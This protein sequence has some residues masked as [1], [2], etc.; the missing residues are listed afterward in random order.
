MKKLFLAGLLGL[1][2]SSGAIA[3]EYLIEEM[4]SLK[5]TLDKNDPDRSILSIRLADLYFD[6]SIQEGEND[7]LVEYREKA[8]KLYLDV[9]NGRDGIKKADAKNATLIRYNIARVLGKLSRFDEARNYYLSVFESEHANER[10]K[11][12]AAFSLAE[13]YEEKVN[14]NK[15]DQYYLAG[16]ELCNSVESCNYAHYKRAWLHYKEVKLDTAISELKQSLFERDGSVREKVINDLLL[17]FSS[18]LTNGEKELAYIKELRSKTGRKDLVRKLVEAFYAAGNRIAGSTVLVELNKEK[19]DPFYEMRLLE[20]FYGFR[21][22]DLV[23]EYL[24]KL[25]KR[26]QKELPA[27]KEEAK[28]FKAMLKRVIVQFDS[29]AESNP[30]YVDIL[31]R[32]IDRYLAFYPNDDMRKKMQQGWLK[33]ESSEEN[34]IA[35]LKKWIDEDI[36][37]GFDDE[38]IRKLRQTRLSMA[39]KLKKSDIVKVESLAIYKLLTKQKT[40]EAREFRYVYAHENYKSKDFNIAL[41]IFMELADVSVVN[42]DEYAIKSQHLALDILNQQKKYNEIVIQADAWLNFDKVLNDKN[43]ASDLKEIKNIRKQADFEAV[44]QL[45]ENRIALERFYKFCFDKVYEEKSCQNAKVL[46]IKLADQEKLISLLE[47]AKDEKALV[48][49]YE[50][51]GRF[52]DTAKLQEKFELTRNADIPVYLKI[53]LLYEVDENFSDRDRILKKL[54]NKIRRDKKIESKYETLVFN[55]LDQAGLID[56]SSLILPWNAERKISLANRLVTIKPTKSNQSI[57]TKGLSYT[58][59]TWAKHVLGEAQKLY[60]RQAKTKFYG[61]YS[62]TLFKRR[63]SRIE[64]FSRYAKGY[65]EGANSE[66]RIY[67]LDLLAKAY[68]GLGAEILNTPIPEGLTEE[69]LMQVQANLTQMASPY[70]LVAEDYRRLQTEEI[71]KLE[72]D[73]KTLISGNLSQENLNYASLIEFEEFK[74]QRTADVDFNK[75]RSYKTQ[76]NQKPNDLEILTKMKDE[77]VNHNNMRMAAYFT[78]RI[79]ALKET[80]E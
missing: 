76:L 11:R 8:L 18:D 65:L 2:L 56:N 15:A 9:L 12:E 55:T 37:Y 19:P 73:E 75:I 36:S 69:I 79:Q 39:Q 52:S 63:I 30:L 29:E 38:H 17:F 72:E 47:K 80:H 27:T 66:T 35:R 48:V 40:N 16:I 78:G 25:E 43:L 14:F 32:S 6:V 33:V 34:K 13:Y 7:N 68:E 1:T 23:T 54:I 62:K 53:A 20:E 46:A 45:G 59:P 60:K 41:P 71:D 31:K 5:S 61:R 24:S 57:L 10:L 49:E 67:L 26:S 74:V 64:K 3:D 77:F 58:G 28:E 22:V 42:V 70:T 51:M 4:E 50:L 21:D 44:T